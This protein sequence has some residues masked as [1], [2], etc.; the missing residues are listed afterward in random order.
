ML[1]RQY[2][3]FLCMLHLA[4]PNGNILYNHNAFVKSKKLTL[5][6]YYRLYSDFSLLKFSTDGF[7]LC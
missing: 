6:Q 7:F 4:S 5:L 3:V 1:Q 2:R